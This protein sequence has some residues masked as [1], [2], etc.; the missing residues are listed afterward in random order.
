MRFFC[1]ATPGLG[2]LVQ[3]ELNEMGWHASVVIE[4]DGRSDIVTFS[5]HGTAHFAVRQAD[6]V[7]VELGSARVRELKPLVEMLLE[8]DELERG[9]SVWSQHRGSLRAR[10]SYRVIALQN[11]GLFTRTALRRAMAEHVHKTRPKWRDDRDPSTSNSGSLKANRSFSAWAYES[12]PGSSAST[13]A[14]KRNGRVRCA[15]A[16]RPR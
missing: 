12:R 1:T 16:S 7:F 14:D 10:M 6:D 11:E 15:R 9:L 2:P 5:A 4:W 3:L 13:V 8:P